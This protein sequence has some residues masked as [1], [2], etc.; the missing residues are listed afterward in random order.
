MNWIWISAVR[1]LRYFST[2]KDILKISENLWGVRVSRELE[3][4]WSAQQRPVC[5]SLHSRYR[6]N[7]LHT[8]LSTPGG[9]P[10]LTAGCCWDQ[11]SI[12]LLPAPVDN[13]SGDVCDRRGAP[14]PQFAVPF[15]YSI[16]YTLPVRQLARE[17]FPVPSRLPNSISSNSVPYKLG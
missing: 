1:E 14:P 17:K 11:G 9:T 12:F 8:V 6:Y 4:Q 2:G 16:Q 13:W 10:L 15:N 7:N 3:T 5:H